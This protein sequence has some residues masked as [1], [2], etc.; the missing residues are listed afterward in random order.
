MN[1]FEYT[2]LIWFFIGLGFFVLEIS[3]P[4][5]IVFFFGLG[6]WIVAITLG[7]L[8]INLN[9]N[10][11]IILFIVTSLISLILLR[12]YLKNI[13]YG[14]QRIRNF[15]KD[16]DN[17]NMHAIVSKTIKANEFG[18]I[19]GEIDSIGSDVLE[20]D[21]NFNYY[22]FPVTV[23]LKESFIDHKGKKLP[24]ITG[25]SL[26]A[27]IILRQRPVISLFTETLMPFWDSLENF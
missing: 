21:E 12:A 3:A 8:K 7:L 10:E 22:R 5:F 14:D 17:E 13:F 24:L 19:E 11:Q 18:E 25:M 2:Y 16:T 20:P 27:N 15:K 9:L 1:I 23:N 4:G 6:S 26:R